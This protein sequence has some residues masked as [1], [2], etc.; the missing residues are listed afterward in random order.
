MTWPDVHNYLDYRIFLSDWLQWK[1]EASP[2]FSHRGFVRR[3]GQ[4]SPSLLVDIVAG[5]RSMTPI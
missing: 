2:R 1:K 3:V 5:R 4:K